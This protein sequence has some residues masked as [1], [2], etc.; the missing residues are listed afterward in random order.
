LNDRSLS[1]VISTL[2]G[3]RWQQFRLAVWPQSRAL[4]L[5][6]FYLVYLLC[7]WEVETL[8]LIVP[9]GRET[10]AVRIFNMLHYGHAG[11]V[12]ALCVWMLLLGMAPQDR[13]GGACSPPSF[14]LPAVKRVGRSLAPPS[15]A[16]LFL[17]GCTQ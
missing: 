2:G 9:P 10:L 15:L 12:D 14:S 4:F 5:A 13:F 11:Q 7:L 6:G 1:D 16:L 3:S 17:S 8:I